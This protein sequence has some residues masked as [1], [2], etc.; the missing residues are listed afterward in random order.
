M[1]DIK[2]NV[3]ASGISPME[4]GRLVDCL[5][6]CVLESI[7]RR[8][9]TKISVNVSGVTDEGVPY[10]TYGIDIGYRCPK[11]VKEDYKP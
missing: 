1:Y 6:R 3:E 7:P 8:P 11:T 5:S 9:D 4:R 10:G 2:I